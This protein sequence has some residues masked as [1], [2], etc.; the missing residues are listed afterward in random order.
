MVVAAC[1]PAFAAPQDDPSKDL[2]EIVEELQLQR[3]QL[4]RLRQ[5]M[6]ILLPRLEA[7]GRTNAIQLM[8]EGLEFLGDRRESDGSLTLEELMDEAREAVER[9]QLVQSLEQQ[10]LIVEALSHLLA[11]LMDRENLESLEGVARRAAQIAREP[12][13]TVG[14]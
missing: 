4:V 7:E 10:A 2:N 11:I 3:R 1:A 12:G 14:A 5:T 8:K 9:G 6:E 13:A